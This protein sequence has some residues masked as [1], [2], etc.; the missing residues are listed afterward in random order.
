[1]FLVWILF[2][3]FF[4]S[5][6]IEKQIPVLQRET[7]LPSSVSETSG[8]VFTDGQLWT[9]NDHG[10]Y[11]E[12]YRLD[13]VNG[14][15]LQIIV[16]DNFPNT[17]WEEISADEDNLYIGDFGNNLGMRRDLKI[18]IV[19]KSQITNKKIVHV[20]AEAINFR[21]SDQ[22]VF[23]KN[24]RNNF[25][26]EAMLAMSDSIYLFTKDRGDNLTHVYAVSKTSGTYVVNSSQSFVTEGRICGASFNLEDRSIALIGYLPG[27]T[28]SFILMLND[29]KD[30][31]FFSGSHLRVELPSSIR[32]WKT[33][34]IAWESGSRFFV[35]C[36]RT[37]SHRAGLFL[38]SWIGM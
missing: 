36:E 12:I 20:K 32:H 21:Y 19:R 11:P 7:D 34:G 23:T 33:E 6:V 25:D 5:T 15:V 22:I 38:F 17:D 28:H 10:G 9:Q 1:M 13:S 3:W 8:L 35:S 16:I 27:T 30:N 24:N 37:N 2:F 29:Y 4:N 26:C 18:L 14:K 31:Q